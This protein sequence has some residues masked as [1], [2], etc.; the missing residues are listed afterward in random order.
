MA[1]TEVVSQSTAR[2]HLYG[3]GGGGGPFSSQAPTTGVTIT[4]AMAVRISPAPLKSPNCCT[5]TMS[6]SASAPKANP[7]VTAAM[8]TS[9]CVR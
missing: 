1:G 9:R 4:I 5:A 3:A 7:A 6:E 8:R 2:V